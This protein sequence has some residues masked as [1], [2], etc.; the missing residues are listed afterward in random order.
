MLLPLL[1]ELRARIHRGQI[2]R[3]G[4]RQL[5]NLLVSNLVELLVEL[6]VLRE[7]LLVRREVLL[8]LLVQ[9]LFAALRLRQRHFLLADFL[10][11]LARLGLSAREL[12]LR[13]FLRLSYLDLELLGELL[14]M[15]LGK[16]SDL[17]LM[18]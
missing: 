5:P 6:L 8:D 9:L 3:R 4:G 1:L 12:S 13:R 2:C 7:E 16:L 10:L 18:S 17:L 11:Q 14:L 15:S